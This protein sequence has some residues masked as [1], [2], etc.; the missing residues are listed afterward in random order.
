MKM[1]H[2]KPPVFERDGLLTRLIAAFMLAVFLPATVIAAPLRYCMGQNGHRAIEFVHAKHG[3]HANTQV[4]LGALLLEP[5]RSALHV[6]GPHCQDKLLLPVAAKSE[7]RFLAAPN[8][9][10]VLRPDPSFHL[11]ANAKRRA[12][13][14]LHVAASRVCETDPRLR[15]RRTV[16]LLN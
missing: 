5:R 13:C 2:Q 1:T 3:F 14:K 16:V 9:A 4:A 12:N 6:L 15:T 8:H 10:P 11:T 7:K